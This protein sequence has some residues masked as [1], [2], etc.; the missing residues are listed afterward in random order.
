MDEPPLRLFLQDHA[1]PRSHYARRDGNWI[2]EPSWPS[3]NITPTQFVL[4][5]DGSLS[6]EGGGPDAPLS[7]SSPLWVG[8]HAGKWCSYARPGDQ[9]GD[10]RRD[11]SGSLVFD[12]PPLET[13]VA[14]AGDARLRL[15]FR[16]DQLVAQVAAR[17]VDVAP[18]GAGTRVSYGLLN[19]THCDGH[20][21]PRPLEVGRDYSVEVPFKHVAQVFRTGHRIRLS[22]S[23]SYFPIAWPA[24]QR[25]QLT[26]LPGQSQ[27]VLPVRAATDE[28]VLDFGAPRAGAPLDLTF[29]VAP[30]AEWTVT[31]N[32][33][34]GRIIIEVGTHEGDASITSHRFRHSADG[35]ERYWFL[36]DDPTSAVG[37][38]T[39]THE[40]SARWVARQDCD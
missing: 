38:V 5:G 4:G 3:P 36:P 27:L 16:V 40:I 30:K 39:W 9:P 18:D 8:V 12:T 32:A 24:P 21:N 26:V 10:Q 15:T 2:T 22:L 17:L 6:N 25:T 14:I 35:R 7:I 31:E 34:T 20:E 29:D 11:D 13:D 28:A 1:E 37:E 19:L 33:E 23:T